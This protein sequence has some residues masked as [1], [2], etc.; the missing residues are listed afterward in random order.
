MYMVVRGYERIG[1]IE[2]I[3]LGN[4]QNQECATV[5]T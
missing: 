4:I 3:R 5:Q 1:E 2:A